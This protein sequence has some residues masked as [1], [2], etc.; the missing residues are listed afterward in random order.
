MEAKPSQIFE[1]TMTVIVAAFSL[2]VIFLHESLVTQV[3]CMSNSVAAFCVVELT[4]IDKLSSLWN[5]RGLYVVQHSW[6]CSIVHRLSTNFCCLIIYRMWSSCHISVYIFVSFA[7]CSI[8]YVGLTQAR[9]NVCNIIIIR[10]KYFC[11]YTYSVKQFFTWLDYSSTSYCLIFK[12]WYPRQ[13]CLIRIIAIRLV[14]LYNSLIL[15]VI[16]ILCW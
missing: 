14:L 11:L 5:L 3:W 12:C 8:V 15:M 7:P 2:G 16:I 6:L 1:P 10:S 9:P 4:L 13:V